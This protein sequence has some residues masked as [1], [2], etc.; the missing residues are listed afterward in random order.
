MPLCPHGRLLEDAQVGCDSNAIKDFG[1][2]HSTPIGFQDKMVKSPIQHFAIMQRDIYTDQKVSPSC[3]TDLFIIKCVC[4]RRESCRSE[5]S[6]VHDPKVNNGNLS[7]ILTKKSGGGGRSGCSRSISNLKD[8]IHGSKRYMEKPPTCS[9]RSIGSSEF[10]NPITHEVV[11]SDST[12]EIKITGVGGAFQESSSC[13]GGGSGGSSA[14]GGTLKL[15]IPGPGGH[16]H[17]HTGSSTV[18]RNTTRSFSRKEVSGINGVPSNPRVTELVE[19]DSSRKIVE[20]ICRTGWSKS[21]NNYGNIERILKPDGNELLRFYGMTVECPLG[22]NGSSSLCLS[23]R[24]NVCR[25][26]RHGFSA[27]KELKGGIVGVFTT[28]TSGRALESI[29]L[30]DDNSILRKALI[31]CRVIAGRVHRPLENFQ[32]LAS[33]SGFDSLAGK[34]GF[35]RISRNFFC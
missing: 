14:F 26:L 13:H 8:V 34:M 29:E 24:C 32:E 15:G 2:P 3:Q 20:L 7:N 30:R 19:G 25:I 35:A 5:P 9:P 10:L 12:C 1:F 33:Q 16:N 31:V 22:T 11:F 4:P 17:S 21:D 18:P 27:K 28:S 6:E 23:D